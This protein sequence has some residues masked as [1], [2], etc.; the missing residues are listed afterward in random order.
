MTMLKN[1]VITANRNLRK[2]KTYAFINVFALSLAF[3]CSLFLFGN[4]AHDFSYDQFHKDKQ[5]KLSRLLGVSS[6]IATPLAC[7][8]MSRWL[9]DFPYRMTVSWLLVLVVGITAVPIAVLT[10]GF[11]TLKVAMANPVKRRRTE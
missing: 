4:V 5:K 11:H 1:Y 2:Y 3:I 6:L 9:Q 7:W 8:L 10:V